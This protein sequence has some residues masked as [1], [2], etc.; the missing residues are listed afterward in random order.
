MS[1]QVSSGVSE[2]P[3][4]P[5]QEVPEKKSGAG[6][7]I[8]GI[9]GV[10]I[11]AA[12][13]IGFKFGLREVW[14]NIT[15]SVTTAKVGDC[16]SDSTKNV[17]DAKVVKC[18]AAEAKNKVVGVVEDK[19]TSVEFDKSDNPCTAF[20]TAENAIW[21]GKGTSKGDVWCLEPIKK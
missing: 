18:D 20:A 6:K 7:K 19:F 11:I 1:D 4:Q 15:G 17:D 14:D 21:V 8:L 16:I 13:V 12:V 5:V 9:L 2:A 3:E 10:I